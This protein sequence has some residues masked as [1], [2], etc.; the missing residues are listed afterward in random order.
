MV[1]GADKMDIKVVLMLLFG[2][3]Y[4]CDVTAMNKCAV[5]RLVCAERV[6]LCVPAG[7]KSGVEV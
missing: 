6:L 3:N 1:N 5:I 7:Q 2:M 4:G